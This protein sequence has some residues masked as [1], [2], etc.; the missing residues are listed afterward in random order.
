MIHPNELPD[1]PDWT[2]ETKPWLEAECRPASLLVALEIPT[3]V[4]LGTD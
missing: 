4:I 2:A 3:N 1:A